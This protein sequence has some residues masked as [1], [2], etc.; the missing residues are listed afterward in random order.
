MH[1]YKQLKSRESVNE[2]A[3]GFP[4]KDRTMN[5]QEIGIVCERY[6]YTWLFEKSGI[7]ASEPVVKSR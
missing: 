7:Q 6:G 1:Y 2:P 4:K 3:R 5:M